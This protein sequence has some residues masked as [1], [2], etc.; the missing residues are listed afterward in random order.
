MKA[1]PEFIRRAASSRLGLCLLAAH[2]V[3]VVWE[4]ALKPSATYA[5]TPCVAE[6]SS[7]VLIAGRLYHWHYESAPLKLITFLDLPAMF[8]AGLASKCFAP[9][10]LCDFTSSWVDAVLILFFA[11]VQWLLFGFVVEALFRR[12]AGGGAG[13]L[14]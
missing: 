2:L 5:K 1:V 6:P 8:L 10:R 9:L 14:R 11:S 7:A 3:Y 12:F 4:F 13:A